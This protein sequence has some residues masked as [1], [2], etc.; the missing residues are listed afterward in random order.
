[1]GEGCAG[2]RV[3]ARSRGKVKPFAVAEAR[4]WWRRNAAKNLDRGVMAELEHDR[5]LYPAVR[6]ELVAQ[7]MAV[8][9]DELLSRVAPG[10]A[11]CHPSRMA[12][13]GT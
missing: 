11:C 13:S 5:R 7:W 8:R 2:D 3:G 12:S 4:K 6:E 9:E 10:L 1:M